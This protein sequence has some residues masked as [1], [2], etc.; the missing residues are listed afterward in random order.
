MAKSTRSTSRRN[1]LRKSSK[2]VQGVPIGAVLFQVLIYLLFLGY[3][4]NLENENRCPCSDTNE[5]VYLKYWLIFLL[6]LTVVMYLMDQA[7]MGLPKPL[8]VLLG[9]VMTF[10]SLYYLYCV[11]V[12][13]REMRHSECSCS[14][15]LIRSV[16]E[17]FALVGVLNILVTF[18]IVFT[19]MLN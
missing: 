13:V 6:G 9:L 11:L 3:V 2:V 8:S 16:M 15:N 5:R 1:S 14:D 7:K 17:V 10:G 18:F 4:L 12:F 19:R